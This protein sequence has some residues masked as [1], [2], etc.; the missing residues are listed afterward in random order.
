MTSLSR[1]EARAT[2]R[3]E[4]GW[5]HKDLLPNARVRDSARPWEQNDI[6]LLTE[7]HGTMS[8]ADLAALLGRSQGSI[9]GMVTRLGLSKKTLWT[10]AEEAALVSLYHN[11]G[12]D[13]VLDLSGFAK[14]IGRDK[15]NV[16][17]KAKSL[18]LVTN[19]RRRTVEQR[20]QKNKYETTSALSAA[21]SEAR[22]R[23][24]RE[25][26]HPRGMAGKRHSDETRR[27]LSETSKAAF[28]LLT[29][30][31]RAERSLKSLK[32]RVAKSKGSIAAKVQ[33]GSWK[34]GWRE[35]GGTR[36]YYRSRW[37]AN[38]ARYLQWLKD[39]GEI[40]DWKY[41]PETFW[42]EAIKRGTR[43][44][45]PDFRVWENNGISTLH[46]VKGWMDQRSRTTLKRMA[47]Y[48]PHEKIILID[49][50]QYR[51]IRLKVMRLI[52]GWEDHERDRYA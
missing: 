10:E 23:W 40:S 16:C 51:A 47:K 2:V 31:E 19:P 45:L 34:A 28:L 5:P 9:R 30:D 42:F 7:K 38:Y 20:K 18:G 33:R 43:S 1:Q 8:L 35:I 26:P 14:T 49:G 32:A 52:D 25:N 15:A 29:E 4:L 22:K 13:G 44:Y 21:L 36:N 6:D 17:R 48:Y 27:R 46:E 24:H 11:A 41:E 39:R 37:E 12:N 3:I 50:P